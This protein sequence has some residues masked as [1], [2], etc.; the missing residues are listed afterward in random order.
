MVICFC[1]ISSLENIR[2]FP[3]MSEICCTQLIKNLFFC[4]K[5]YFDTYNRSQLNPLKFFE[6]IMMFSKGKLIF[7][8]N[9]SGCLV[10]IPIWRQPMNLLLL[11]T[12]MEKLLYGS[13][14]DL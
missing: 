8:M 11:S 4:Q 14:S 12:Q 2:T 1:C 7:F 3:Y 10:T 13:I 9:Y 6:N 5:F